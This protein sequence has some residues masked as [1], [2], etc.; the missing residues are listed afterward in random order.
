MIDVSVIRDKALVFSGYDE[1]IFLRESAKLAYYAVYH[2]GKSLAI[3]KNISL[4]KQSGGVH[5]KLWSGLEYGKNSEIDMELVL[6]A[7]KMKK[8]RVKG[9]YHLKEEFSSN[10]AKRQVEQ[11]E[12]C[13][14]LITESKNEFLREKEKRSHLRL[15]K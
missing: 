7:K 10:M 15:V 14:T 9:D 8:L 5:A 13:L 1:E 2:E 12:R 6:I 4:D 11:M 3:L